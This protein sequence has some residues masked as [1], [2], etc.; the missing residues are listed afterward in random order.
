ML[1]HRGWQVYLRQRRETRRARDQIER[2]RVTQPE[3]WIQS[4]TPLVT[5]RIATYN[6][7]RLVA[8]RAIASAQAQSHANI[9]ILVVGDHCDQ[10]T[11]DAVMSVRDDRIRFVNLEKRGDYPTQ[12]ERR[13]MVAG[14]APMNHA[15]TI[16][17]GAWLAPLDDDDEFTPDHVEALL[18][19][20]RSRQLDFAYGIANMEMSEGVWAPTGSWPLRQGQIIHAAVLYSMALRTMRHD[21][22]SW[23]LHEPGD[24]NLWHRMRDAG[25]RMGFVDQVVTR[26]FLEA[27][28]LLT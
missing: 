26:H 17:E 20:C 27:R 11:A 10:A 8:E 6:R 12:P 25:V 4:P 2:L 23:R 28:H 14:E 18:D 9:E 16:A 3:L 5:V 19:A 24:W 1:F 15:L 13:W 22:D 21:I 7:G